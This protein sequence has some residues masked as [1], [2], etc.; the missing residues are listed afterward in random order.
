MSD[1]RVLL[2][3]WNASG[4]YHDKKNY[5]NPEAIDD[6]CEITDPFEACTTRKMVDIVQNHLITQLVHEGNSFDWMS[7]EE[8]RN[9]WSN[10]LPEGST[11]SG[12]K[13]G[14]FLRVFLGVCDSADFKRAS[15]K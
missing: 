2:D 3:G 11:V 5:F 1:L 12:L 14:Q 7:P 4:W 10:L 9:N 6:E 8:F 13:Y 15:L